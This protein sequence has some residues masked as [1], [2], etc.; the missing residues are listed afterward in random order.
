MVTVDT[1]TAAILAFAP[2][3]TSQQAKPIA[4]AIAEA[5]PRRG[6]DPLLM[7]AIKLAESRGS[8]RHVVRRERNGSCSHGVMQI[9]ASC[10]AA[11]VRRWR[12]LD[13]QMHRAARILH[14]GKRQCIATLR[15]H[16][17]RWHWSARFN[18][19]RGLHYVRVVLGHY[20]RLRRWARRRGV[21]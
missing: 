2:A 7:V 21:T 12:N 15:P 9:N 10:S 20:K 13:L 17:C 4:A 8:C 3:C 1:L 19:G 5:A 6:I 16:W 14:L 18:P 11:A